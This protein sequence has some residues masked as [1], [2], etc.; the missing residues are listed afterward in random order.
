MTRFTLL[1]DLDGTL[2]DS[3]E[4]IQR[5]KSYA[6]E[7][8]GLTAPPDR[9]WLNWIG[10]PLR[11][12][13][14][15][16]TDDETEVERFIAAYREFQLAHHDRLVHAYEGADASLAELRERGHAIGI[17]TSKSVEL[18]ERGLTHVGLRRYVDTIVGFDS[19]ERH[20]PDPEPVRVALE[21]LGGRA[22]RALF[23]GDS[24]HD[25][26]AGNA[27][28]IGTV[29]ALW[30]PFSRQELAP[31]APRFFADRLADLPALVAGL[32]ASP[33]TP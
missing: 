21:R 31:S 4:L 13:F 32:E 24:L 25:M 8:R 22:D 29:A 19:T 23:V 16:Y 9:E 20:K 1:F 2:I 5:S 18:S 15:R 10:T 28:G 11:S 14:Q 27:A 12:M 6:F 3:I 26:H 30:G 17:V 7:A 33:E